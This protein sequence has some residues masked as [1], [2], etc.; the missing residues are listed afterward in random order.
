M[1][2]WG[3]KEAALIANS[4]LDGGSNPAAGIRLFTERKR[5]RFLQP[6]EVSRFFTALHNHPS[7]DMRD[8]FMLALLTGARKMNVAAMRWEDINLSRQEWRIPDTKNNEPHTVPLV[9]EAI[10]LI[11]RRKKKQSSD[12]VF[13]SDSIS[14]HIVSPKKA[15]REIMRQADVADLR[16]HDLRRTLGSWQAVQGASLPIIGKS[17]GHKTATATQIYA[18]L[19]LDPVRASM[20]RATAAMLSAAGIKQPAE[21]QAIKSQAKV[22]K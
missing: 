17:L 16:I 1:I 3:I 13:P 12:F 19:N 2:N 14:G 11:K 4:T 10:T 9:P 20:E 15:W 18:R 5:D 6:D 21:I 8:L 7:E 22:V